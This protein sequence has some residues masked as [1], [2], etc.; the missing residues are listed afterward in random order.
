M[1]CISVKT[2]SPMPSIQCTLCHAVHHA[3]M[4]YQDEIERDVKNYQGIRHGR[5]TWYREGL[6]IVSMQRSASVKSL[7]ASTAW[8]VLTYRRTLYN[9]YLSTINRISIDYYLPRRRTIIS[10]QYKHD[11]RSCWV[12]LKVKKES[13]HSICI[14]IILA[15]SV[16]NECRMTVW[17]L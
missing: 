6:H 11:I 3:S 9:K 5:S 16:Q 2:H 17:M 14:C 1:S 4:D 10:N 15:S 13:Y 12:I 7:V 8:N